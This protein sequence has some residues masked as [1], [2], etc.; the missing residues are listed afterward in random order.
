MTQSD[1]HRILNCSVDWK[2][3]LENGALIERKA[4]KQVLFYIL[5]FM[6]SCCLVQEI[7]YSFELKHDLFYWQF[8]KYAPTKCKSFSLTPLIL[9]ISVKSNVMS[10]KLGNRWLTQVSVIKPH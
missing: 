10:D 4:F 7:S 9:V 5:S 2:I 8:Q 3:L 1:K 6:V